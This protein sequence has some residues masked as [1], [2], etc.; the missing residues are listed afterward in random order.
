MFIYDNWPCLHILRLVNE[1][2]MHANAIAIVTVY[3]VSDCRLFRKLLLYF[4]L[5]VC[6]FLL[7]VVIVN[8]Y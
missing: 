5:Y 3:T 2:E 7:R 4:T 6:V 8:L 1:N